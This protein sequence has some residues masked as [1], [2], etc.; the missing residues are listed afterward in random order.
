MITAVEEG[1]LTSVLDA[2]RAPIRWAETGTSATPSDLDDQAK[3]DLIPRF[4]PI[5]RE[6]VDNGYITI[7]EYFLDNPTP[8]VLSGEQLDAAL[9]DPASWIWNIDLNFR[10]L[11]LLTTDSWDILVNEH[12]SQRHPPTT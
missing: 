6:L 4:A 8:T 3:R 7:A 2:W 5:V 10:V 12:L 1:H 11:E 9:A